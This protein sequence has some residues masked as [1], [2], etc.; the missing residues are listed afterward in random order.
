MARRAATKPR[1][2]IAALVLQGGGALGAY[3][4][5]VIERLFEE[6]GFD[7]RYVSG[8]SIGAITA[9]VLVGAKSGNPVATL[10]ELWDEFAVISSPLIPDSVEANLATFG[11]AAFYRMR[12]DYLA[13]PWWTHFYDVGPI[14]ERLA[15]LVDFTAIRDSN[16]RLVVT[17]TNIKT[18]EI[19]AFDNAEPRRPLTIDHILASGSLPPGFPMTTIGDQAYWDGGLFNNTPLSPLLERV[20]P[21]DAGRMRLFVVN[22]FPSAGRIP[23]NMLAVGDRIVEL[24]FSNKMK[25]DVEIARTINRFVALVE[26]IAERHDIADL[27]RKRDY[28]A[29][30]K[31]KVLGDIIEITNTRDEPVN[32]A[33]DFSRPTIEARIGAGYRDASTA[34]STAN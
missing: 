30:E 6:P 10:R 32:A 26:E 11:N 25:K 19:D 7:L 24:I 3:E 33:S 4:L 31:Y 14:R 34:L 8:V 5:G 9:A 2:T 16:I 15:E 20:H 21:R 1:K 29:L 28:Q 22:L 13:M 17:A 18:G 27:R 12:S 23:E